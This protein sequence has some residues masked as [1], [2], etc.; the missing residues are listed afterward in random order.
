MRKRLGAKLLSLIILLLLVLPLEGCWNR[1]EPEEYAW[2]NY[3]GLDLSADGQVKVTVLVMPP[4]SPVPTGISE[5]NML[6]RKFTATG[7]TVFEAVRNI[8]AYVPKRLFWSYL[9]AVIIG[10]DLAR[11]GVV[12]HLDVLLRNARIRKNAWVFVTKGPVEPVFDINPQVEKNPATLLDYL[13]LTESKF[14]GKSRTLRLKDFQ[15]ELAEPG[16]DPVVSV[17]GIWDAERQR[18]LPAGESVPS[19]SEFALEGSAVFRGDKLLTW[20]SPEDSRFLLL[21]KGE[22]KSSLF[23]IP[24][25]DVPENRVGIEIIGTKGKLKARLQDGKIE[26]TLKIGITG[27]FGDQWL[28]NTSIPTEVLSED[29]R[30]YR[31]LEASLA[32]KVKTGTEA[33]L[34]K[35]QQDW[36]ADIFG[37][38]DYLHNRYPNDWKELQSNWTAYYEQARIAVDVQVKILAPNVMRSRLK[39]GGTDNSGSE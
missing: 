29:P 13:V 33:L 37:I 20:L 19:T 9:Q 6:M 27:N 18:F 15:R 28:N 22:L 25:P 10:E 5:P 17:L 39:E 26:G 30:Y 4:L 3:V 1:I 16:V 34:R 24:D 7:R 11:A 38:G 12:Q 35:A 21:A 23:V 14:L 2:L 31:E 36:Q 8:N 32:E